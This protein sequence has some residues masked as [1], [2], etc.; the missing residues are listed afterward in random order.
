ML[1][2]V[3][4]INPFFFLL[5]FLPFMSSCRFA[6]SSLEKQ[7]TKVLVSIAP[8][9][10]LLES[11]AQKTIEV[12]TI[13][14]SGASSHTYEP[15][16]SQVLEI[17]QSLAWF[18]IGENFEKQL[19]DSIDH[20]KNPFFLVD[21]SKGID[22]I[23][24]EQHSCSHHHDSADIHFWLSPKNLENQVNIMTQNLKKLLPQHAKLYQKNSEKLK[25]KIRDLDLRIQK[26]LSPLKKR[27]LI[28]SHPCLAYFCRDY[29]LEQLSLENE[30]K[31]P[32]AKTLHEVLQKAQTLDVKK[33]L[34]QMQYNNRAA[35]MIAR[36]LDTQVT[37]IDPYREN[38]IAN[39]QLIALAIADEK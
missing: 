15:E 8:Y 37:Y 14:P 24:E 38:V 20:M 4:Q 34:V 7:K 2:K 3:K 27:H 16:P 30:G 17:N 11:I 9:K 19:I 36:E 25:K 1:F 29:N 39:L 22:L 31:E 18:R 13:V 6:P 10:F 35:K 32:L 28:T 33:I 21:L 12:S 23:H 5:L 26:I